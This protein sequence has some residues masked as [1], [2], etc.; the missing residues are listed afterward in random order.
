MTRPMVHEHNVA[1][2]EIID[3]EMNDVEFAKYTADQIAI[4]NAET[5]RISTE[6]ALVDTKAAAIANL[7]AG[8]PL[9]AEQAATMLT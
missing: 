5:E 1:L 6:K 7:V 3:R 2:D 4:A 9:T 8:T